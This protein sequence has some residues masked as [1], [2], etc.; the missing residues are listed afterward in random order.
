M[1]KNEL[2]WL[3]LTLLSATLILTI[4]KIYSNDWNNFLIFR[5]SFNHLKD[6]LQLYIEHPSDHFDFF[7]YSPTF[8]VLMAPWSLLP[9]TLGALLWNM[10][11]TFLLWIGFRKIFPRAQDATLFLVITAAE[12][13]GQLQNFQSNALLTGLFL[14]IF[15]FFENKQWVWAGILIALTV[16]IKIFGGALAL[17]ALFYGGR[18]FLSVFLSS[19]LSFLLLG[20]LPLIWITPNELAQQ[21]REWLHLL[22]W[23]S[24][25]S[26]G[27]SIMGVFKGFTGHELPNL[28]TQLIGL[29]LL[30]APF[31]IYKP[32]TPKHR[33]LFLASLLMWMIV[34]NHKS[35][36]P[37]FIIGMTGFALWFLITEKTFR[38]WSL[39]TTLFFVSLLYSDFIPDSLKTEWVH[40][41]E[42]KV[43]PL[44][45]TWGY[46]QIRYFLDEVPSKTAAV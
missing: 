12:L 7:K 41:L 45:I 18:A 42:M 33:Q 23:D 1:K 2:I 21:Y 40:P 26:Q 39:W 13:I 15:S 44:I 5:S 37:T 32:K 19:T 25:V 10:L 36:S 30:L 43:W 17:L 28:L 31:L 46:L 3:S 35:E 24:S 8:A 27:L 11:N 16:H 22:Q 38:H 4:Q 34:F 9:K 29:A 20:A 6:H 14:L